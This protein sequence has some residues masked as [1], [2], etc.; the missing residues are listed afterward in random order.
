MKHW[1]KNLSRT[2]TIAGFT[3][4]RRVIDLLLLLLLLLL[5]HHHHSVSPRQHLIFLQRNSPASMPNDRLAGEG[6]GRKET[7]TDR[8]YASTNP[9][10]TRPATVVALRSHPDDCVRSPSKSIL[11]TTFFLSFSAPF[12]SFFLILFGSHLLSYHFDLI[13]LFFLSLSLS[14]SVLL[15]SFCFLP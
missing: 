12:F 14:L 9:L 11:F 3:R 8:Q 15:C 5:L 10:P 2:A 1:T 7:L 13:T 4:S 6:G